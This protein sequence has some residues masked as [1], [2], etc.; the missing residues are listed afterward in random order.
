MRTK[1]KEKG[2][3]EKRDVEGELM[4]IISETYLSLTKEG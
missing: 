4:N 3:G 1:E 2:R